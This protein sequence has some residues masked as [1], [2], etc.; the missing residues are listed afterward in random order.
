[1]SIERLKEESRKLLERMEWAMLE[2]TIQDLF[3]AAEPEVQD[4]VLEKLQTLT[5]KR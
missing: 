1:M 2:D 5:R 4:R 3:V